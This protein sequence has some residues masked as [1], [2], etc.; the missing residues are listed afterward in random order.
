M[1]FLHVFAPLGLSPYCEPPERLKQAGLV[2]EYPQ[3]QIWILKIG[4]T[5]LIP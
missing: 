2:A 1:V 3:K 5:R 4:E